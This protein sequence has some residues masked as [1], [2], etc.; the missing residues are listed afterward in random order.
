MAGMRQQQRQRVTGP[1]GQSC[2]SDK[3]KRVKVKM[4]WRRHESA[5]RPYGS[6]DKG[7]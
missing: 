1:E 5:R 4:R 7:R 6:G 2:W 3:G